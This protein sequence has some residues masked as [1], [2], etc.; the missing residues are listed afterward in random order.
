MRRDVENIRWDVR[1]EVE[2][3]RWETR[4]KKLEMKDLRR[5]V[6]NEE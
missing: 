1:Q 4:D 3:K 5:K 2:N 6:R